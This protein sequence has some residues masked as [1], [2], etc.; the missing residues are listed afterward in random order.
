MAQTYTVIKITHGNENIQSITGSYLLGSGFPHL[1]ST[2]L[3]ELMTDFSSGAKVGSFT[4]KMEQDDGVKAA[5]SLLFTGATS[6]D[7]FVLNGTTFTAISSGAAANNQFLT[8]SDDNGTVVNAVTAITASTSAAIS[9]WFTPSLISGSRLNV[10]A[11]AIGTWANAIGFYGGSTNGAIAPSA[12]TTVLTGGVYHTGYG[13]ATVTAATCASGDTLIINSTTFTASSAPSANNQILAS[14]SSIYTAA[15]NA[16]TAI[17][18]STSV[19]VTGLIGATNY[20]QYIQL[21][22]KSRGDL[23]NGIDISKTGTSFT[24]SGTVFTGGSLGTTTNYSFGK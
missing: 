3:S 13:V 5:T 20:A 4:V 6:G 22:T 21:A 17:T 18:A 2:R 8:G 11:I 24:V 16:T 1:E 14:T 12:T 19:G 23:G 10:Q 7:T 9:G 15:L